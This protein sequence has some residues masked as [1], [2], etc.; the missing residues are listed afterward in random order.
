[1]SDN[2]NPEQ[3]PDLFIG[4]GQILREAREKKGLEIKDVAKQLHLSKQ[5][6][7]DIENDDY[8]RMSSFTYA[9]GYLR[10]YAKL[11]GFDENEI[12]AA[13][14]N[15][16]LREKKSTRPDISV[17]SYPKTKL[18]KKHSHRIRWLSIGIF[19]VFIFVIALWWQS[20]NKDTKPKSLDNE[21]QQIILP[22]SN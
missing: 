1:M 7:I 19:M 4:P 13:F 14:N 17:I 10:S 22:A 2:D 12:I 16:G 20:K 15:L 21:V 8:E 11:V 6:I 9:R 3:T 18:L 5:Y